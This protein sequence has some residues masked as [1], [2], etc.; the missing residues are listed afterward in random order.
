VQ[1]AIGENMEQ[2]TGRNIADRL[3][4]FAVGVIDLSEVL[5]S[6]FLGNHIGCQI[7]RSATSAGANYEEARGAE[8]KADF[9]HKLGVAL[10]ELKESRY[11][12]KLISKTKICKTDTKIAV[13]QGECEEL[14]AII[15]KSII[16]TKR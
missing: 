16:T 11:W 7:T 3:I 1:F 8:S 10:K 2:E 13:L 15:G 14:C 9:I 6:S 4:D 12:L 5:P